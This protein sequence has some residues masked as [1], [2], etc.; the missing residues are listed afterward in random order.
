MNLLVELKVI[1]DN[2]L[3]KIKDI[4]MNEKSNIEKEVGI[5]NDFL[6]DDDYLIIFVSEIVREINVSEF[7]CF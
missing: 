3:M 7:E 4:L 6:M 1:E 2:L 5:L